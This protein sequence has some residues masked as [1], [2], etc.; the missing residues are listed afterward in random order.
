MDLH[1]NE[2]LLFRGHPTW[3]STIAFYFKGL[4]IAAAVGAIAGIWTKIA[5]DH[6]KTGTVVIV[7]VVAFAIV[8]VTGFI[9]RIAVTYAI[10]NQRLYIRRGIISRHIQE[11]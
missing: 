9:R 11:T 2:H 7:A 8:L 1:P 3:R 5:E 4:V 10:S 6:V